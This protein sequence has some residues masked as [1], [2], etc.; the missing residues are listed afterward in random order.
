MWRWSVS[1]SGRGILAILGVATFGLALS[2]TM[3]STYLPKVARQFT[4]STAVIGVIVG[5]EG[6]MA[7]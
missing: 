1:G 5:A 3:V 6:L 2:I 7:L 4:T